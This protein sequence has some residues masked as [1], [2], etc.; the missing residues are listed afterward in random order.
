VA[1]Q[2]NGPHDVVTEVDG[3]TIE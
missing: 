1:G 3:A 2:G